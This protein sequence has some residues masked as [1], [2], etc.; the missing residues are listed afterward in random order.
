MKRV[1][2][3]AQLELATGFLARALMSTNDPGVKVL[4]LGMPFEIRLAEFELEKE[5][6]S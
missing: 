4:I 3:V 5:I 2:P 1:D 6:P